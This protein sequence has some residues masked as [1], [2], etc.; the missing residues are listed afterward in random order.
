MH[1]HQVSLVKLSKSIHSEHFQVLQATRR[2]TLEGIEG[3]GQYEL[4]SVTSDASEAVP[5]ADVIIIYYVSNYHEFVAEHLAPHLHSGQIVVIS[6]GYLG[7]LLFEKKLRKSKLVALPLF[8][9]FETLPYSSRI[10]SPGVVRISS[11]NLRHPFATYPASRANECQRF[12]SPVLGQCV[13]RQNILEVALHNPN[14]IIHTIG[15]LMN[16]GLIEGSDKDFSMYRMG[17]PPSM[18]NLVRRLD[19]EKMQVMARIGAKPA[20]YFEEFILRTFE[21]LS[22]DPMEGFRRYASETTAILTTLE[23]RYITEDVPM[24]L[25]LLS[26]AG[27]ATGVPTPI[28]DS[29]IHLAGA[30]LPNHDF[31]REARTIESIWPG[32]FGSMLSAITA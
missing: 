16:V 25:G 13:P 15:M 27:R 20:T 11:R 19:A 30:L 12:L 9:E 23:H 5:E 21:D 26:S 1:G 6:P 18:W 8:A 32:D 17:F 14:L 2:I 28:C 7:S 3:T 10:R 29:L 4:A 24:G 31:W 22:I